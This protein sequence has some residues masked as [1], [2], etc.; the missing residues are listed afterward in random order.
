MVDF[1]E[2]VREPI[3]QEA[4]LPQI[5]EKVVPKE[6]PIKVLQDVEVVKPQRI[7]E[8]ARLTP[9]EG[10]MIRRRANAT[11]RLRMARYKRF[12]RRQGRRLRRKDCCPYYIEN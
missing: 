8:R 2:P 4:P 7:R 12:K 1:W 3:K 5:Q 6:I 10:M 11:M 9:E